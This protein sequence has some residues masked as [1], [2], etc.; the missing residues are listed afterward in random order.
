LLPFWKPAFCALSSFISPQLDTMQ[1]DLVE[2]H[3]SYAVMGS[4]C[5]AVCCV[6]SVSIHNAAAECYNRLRC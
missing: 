3:W 1:H 2:F 4:F 6:D 5:I